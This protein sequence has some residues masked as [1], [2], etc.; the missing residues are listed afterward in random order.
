MTVLP[1]AP[2]WF[3]AQILSSTI[4]G[5]VAYGAKNSIVV[6]KCKPQSH[7]GHSTYEENEDIGK[8]SQLRIAYISLEGLK[9]NIVLLY[10]FL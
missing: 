10:P 3:S 8:I 6:L 1:P 9:T 4:K 2:N 7:F 5:Y